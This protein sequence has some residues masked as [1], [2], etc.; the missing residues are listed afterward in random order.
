[1]PM[2]SRRSAEQYREILI[3]EPAPKVNET[4]HEHD[5]S[6]F[7]IREIWTDPVAVYKGLNESQVAK[8]TYNENYFGKCTYWSDRTEE[9]HKGT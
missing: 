2:M 9:I 7:C 5:W 8:C 4:Q 6:D 1:M 3:G